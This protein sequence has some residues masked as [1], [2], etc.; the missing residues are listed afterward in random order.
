[1]KILKE[2][3]VDIEVTQKE[4]TLHF[5]ER[6]QRYAVAQGIGLGTPVKS[7]LVDTNHPNGLEIHTITNTG[8]VFI[9][10]EQSKKL[11]TL[12]IARPQQL[13]RYYQATNQFCPKYLLDLGYKHYLMEANR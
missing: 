6:M 2:I 5:Y 8:I 9:Q 4:Q 10:N 1:M 13:K 12:L 11:I 3:E 7:F